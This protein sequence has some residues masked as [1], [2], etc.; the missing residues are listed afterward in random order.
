MS[1]A[2]E[3]PARGRLMDFLPLSTA[4]CHL[5]IVGL[6]L[7]NLHVEDGPVIRAMSATPVLRRISLRACSSE[8]IFEV[9]PLADARLRI[10]DMVF[11]DVACESIVLGIWSDFVLANCRFTNSSVAVGPPPVYCIGC[12]FEGG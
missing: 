11:V 6:D 1:F 5:S 12:V 9:L 7:Q 4:A 2:L 8:P 10:E 3:P